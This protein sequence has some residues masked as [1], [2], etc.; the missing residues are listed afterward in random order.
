MASSS[1]HDPPTT[2]E[3]ESPSVLAVRPDRAAEMLGISRSTLFAELRAGR[4]RSCRVGRARVL[5]VEHL[6][7][8][9]RDCEEQA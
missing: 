6:Q 5:R 4:L 9:L 2:I 1:R 3:D 8:W 7:Q